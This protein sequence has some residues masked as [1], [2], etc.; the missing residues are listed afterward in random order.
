MRTF[1]RRQSESWA[2]RDYYYIHPEAGGRSKN[3]F[4]QQKFVTERT[5]NGKPTSPSLIIEFTITFLLGSAWPGRS[6]LRTGPSLS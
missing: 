3:C 1:T 2:V 5:L 6:N 4:S